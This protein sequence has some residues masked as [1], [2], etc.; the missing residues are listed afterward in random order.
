[1]EGL[2]SSALTGYL[3]RIETLNGSKFSDWKQ[4]IEITLGILDLDLTLLEDEHPKPNNESKTIRGA[5]PD[6]DNAESF[7]SKEEEQFVSPIKALVITLMTKLQTI[8]DDRHC[9][10]RDHIMQMIDITNQSMSMDMEISEGFFGAIHSRLCMHSIKW[11]LNDVQ[12]MCVQEEERLNQNKLE[13]AYLA[14]TISSRKVTFR[15]LENK[16]Y[17]TYANY[18]SKGTTPQIQKQNDQKERK[19]FFCR[20]NWQ[21]KRDCFQYKK[22]L[23]NKDI[24]QQSETH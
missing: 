21:L 20:K 22:Q 10:V 5:I 11:N 19:Y 23:K 1:M 3:A 16:G 9:F 15:A 8:R 6:E 2:N 18:Q 24:H 4:K 12:I 17:G 7:M 14:E 13:V